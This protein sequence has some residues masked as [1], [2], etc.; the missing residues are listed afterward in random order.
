MARSPDLSST[1]RVCMSAASTTISSTTSHPRPSLAVSRKS[2][3]IQCSGPSHL[4]RDS[5]NSR[6]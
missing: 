2:V 1:F 4:T 3:V 6:A 5:G